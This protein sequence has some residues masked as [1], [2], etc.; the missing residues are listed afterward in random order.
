M[1]VGL[2]PIPARPCHCSVQYEQLSLSLSLT[3]S[4][5]GPWRSTIPHPLLLAWASTL[6]LFLISSLFLPPSILS[7]LSHFFSPSHLSFVRSSVRPLHFPPFE[8]TNGEECASLTSHSH[9]SPPPGIESKKRKKREG[10]KNRTRSL[11]S[12]VGL[13]QTALLLDFCRPKYTQK[14][15]VGK[16]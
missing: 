11:T 4:P 1:V 3:L 16:K 14:E 7:F 5:N 2:F 6:F 10:N 8:A 9:A 13:S 12:G 15:C